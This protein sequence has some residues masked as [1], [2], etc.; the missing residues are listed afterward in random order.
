[1]QDAAAGVTSDGSDDID[2][3]LFAWILHS[4]NSSMSNRLALSTTTNR[5]GAIGALQRPST[6]VIIPPEKEG[7]SC[8]HGV[9]TYGKKLTLDRANLAQGD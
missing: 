1:M 8:E 7:R 5:F 6:P 4:S 3:F 2:D 9:H